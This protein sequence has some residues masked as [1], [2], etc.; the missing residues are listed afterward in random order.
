[1]AHFKNVTTSKDP[2]SFTPAEYAMKNCFF[3]SD[4]KLAAQGTGA[5]KVNAVV[6]GRKTWESIPDKFRPLANR[7]NV[8]LSR[9]P[10]LENA[11]DENGMV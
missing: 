11:N 1:M 10:H 5:E 2:L 9:N 7:L 6:M 4:L 3:Q 8:V